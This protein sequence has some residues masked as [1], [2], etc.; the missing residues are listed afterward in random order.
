[1]SETAPSWLSYLPFIEVAWLL[2]KRPCDE[3]AALHP[4]FRELILPL[5]QSLAMRLSKT[6]APCL[7]SEMSLMSHLGELRRPTSRE[8]YLEFVGR[9]MQ[10]NL[11]SRLFERYG[12]LQEAMEKV[13]AHWKETVLEFF[14]R[15]K[16]DRARIEEHFGDG[17]LHLYHAYMDL[18]DPHKEGRTVFQVDFQGATKTHRLIY[19]PRDLAVEKAFNLLLS[20]INRLGPALPFRQLAVLDEKGYGWVEFVEHKPCESPEQLKN[21]YFRS[22]ANLFLWYLLEGTDAHFENVI[23]CGEHPIMIDQE[24][25][26][27]PGPLKEGATPKPFQN[28]ILRTGLLPF[29]N[30]AYPFGDNFGGITAGESDLIMQTYTQWI[31]I[32]T[33]QMQLVR[34][35]GIVQSRKHQAGEG[36]P[37][38]HHIE[39][40]V[41]GFASLF[42]LVEKHKSSLLESPALKALF[43]AKTR[44]VIQATATYGNLMQALSFPS[45]MRSKEE[46]VSYLKNQLANSYLK[47]EEI[48]ASEIEQLL[49]R[50]IPYFT[51]SPNS[52]NI[53]ASKLVASDFIPFPMNDLVRKK[54]E[55]LNKREELKQI[56]IL[57]N[58]LG[59]FLP[60]KTP[61]AAKLLKS[62][63]LHV[64]RMVAAKIIASGQHL[65]ESKPGDIYNGRAGYALFFAALHRVLGEKKWAIEASTILQS[66]KVPINYST[67][68]AFDGAGG[69]LYS[70][71]IV[72]Q[73][74][75]SEKIL[76]RCHVFLRDFDEEA[77]AKYPLP[78][79]VGG[80]SGFLTVQLSAHRATKE[81]GFMRLAL[82]SAE[83]LIRLFEEGKGR[84]IGLSHGLAGPS[85]AL[86][87]LF[88]RTHDPRFLD[89]ARRMA[90][91]ERS[92]YMKEGFVP[93]HISWCHG[94]TGIGFARLVT[95]EHLQDEIVDQEIALALEKT[96]YSLG[97]ESSICCGDLGRIEFL[98][99]YAKR[100]KSHVIE[101]QARHFLF[102]FMGE[103]MRTGGANCGLKEGYEWGFMQGIAGIGYSLMRLS[104]FDL[105]QISLLE[106]ARR[107]S[108]KRPGAQVQG[109]E[110]P[111]FR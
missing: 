77:I 25:L 33:D 14:H 26:M 87:R 35:R 9:L 10:E 72:G 23:S 74:L 89:Y 3:I 13:L 52:K 80:L 71:L 49:N 32:N 41:H 91:V 29:I 96:K 109:V 7:T 67:L 108:L 31:H 82:Q 75:N 60:K 61:H 56:A 47:G 79:F 84:D 40:I 98:L 58:T 2:S 63:A 102:L 111:L 92:I 65:K 5:R 37:F 70:H 1:M 39:D 78:D 55:K 59:C 22:G 34:S 86:V 93:R 100:R 53:Y 97:Q 42:E 83:Q 105:P 48:Q 4:E 66:E 54:I 110:R 99:E 46:A 19:K 94:H 104:G 64:A 11:L 24:T 73:L 27:H 21:F 50:D 95:S 18:S 44:V 106:G 107:T 36:N 90:E 17:P 57:K 81:R 16:N 85:F 76:K 20:E 8:R 15:F 38:I 69:Q 12:M 101:M 28:S 30:R 62:H 68:S 51:S 88:E 6:L 43:A 103:F 45:L